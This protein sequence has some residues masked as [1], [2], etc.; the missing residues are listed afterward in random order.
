MGLVISILVIWITKVKE[1]LAHQWKRE[2]QDNY[3]NNYN[4][5][6]NIRWSLPK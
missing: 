1:L 3:K 2:I 4:N 6:I 5:N